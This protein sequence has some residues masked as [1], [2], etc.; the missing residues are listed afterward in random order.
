MSF[1]RRVWS[2]FVIF[3]FSFFRKRPQLSNAEF[4]R[5]LSNAELIRMEII[6]Q[7]AEREAE[8][9]KSY[10]LHMDSPRKGVLEND[11][12]I[13]AEGWTQVLRWILRNTSTRL[14]LRTLTND[15]VLF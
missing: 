1:I 12:P 4:I 14:Y 7:H 11:E 15:Q 2:S 3:I 8:R 5:M 9:A 6:A 13:S 10:T